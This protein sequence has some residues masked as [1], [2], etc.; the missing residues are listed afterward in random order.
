MSLLELTDVAETL[1]G[2]TDG[3][4]QTLIDHGEAY[5]AARL[6]IEPG[7]DTGGAGSLVLP[8]DDL[9]EID[10]G[11]VV[12]ETTE[13]G[14]DFSSTIT[15]PMGARRRIMNRFVEADVSD[16]E[17]DFGP[18]LI[19][20]DLT[21]SGDSAANF[22]TF[23]WA[24]WSV[25]FQDTRLRFGRGGRFELTAITGFTRPKTPARIKRAILKSID[26]IR[27]HQSASG[28]LASR[29]LRSER[30]GPATFTYGDASNSAQAGNA[31]N[32]EQ[33]STEAAIA[34]L[35]RPWARPRSM[36]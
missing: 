34:D 31:G 25:S 24:P 10:S 29:Q 11:G 18:I 21:W 4:K 15:S 5:V 9:G 14:P 30:I 1:S 7:Q 35:I 2:L 26:L 32:V 3:Q 33:F 19:V 22:D 17:L 23:V 16:L 13:G 36:F 6:G 12:E 27:S 20:E 28:T 8:Q